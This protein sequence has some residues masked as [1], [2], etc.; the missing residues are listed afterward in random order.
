MSFYGGERLRLN[1]HD[2]DSGVLAQDAIRTLSHKEFLQEDFHKLLTA[3]LSHAP[4]QRGKDSIAK[5]IVSLRVPAEEYYHT[6]VKTNGIAKG[7]TSGRISP[8]MVIAPS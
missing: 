1:Q 7:E 3:M 2:F 6:Q 8:H 5:N 4:T